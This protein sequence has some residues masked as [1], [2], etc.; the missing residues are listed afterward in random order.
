MGTN[1]EKYGK[2]E[3]IRGFRR[4]GRIDF[5]PD[6][7]GPARL[8]SAV[9]WNDPFPQALDD[10]EELSWR[11]QQMVIARMRRREQLVSIKLLPLACVL[12]A[13]FVGGA[14]TWFARSEWPAA[15]FIIAA[16]ITSGL[17]FL[18]LVLMQFFGMWE[19]RLTAWVEAFKDSHGLSTKAEEEVWKK[20]KDVSVHKEEPLTGPERPPADSDL[21][22][23]APMEPNVNPSETRRARREMAEKGLSMDSSNGKP[24]IDDRTSVESGSHAS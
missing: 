1:E 4:V 19:P 20:K 16:G 13:V 14:V 6:A 23:P 22:M 9:L 7:K 12:L 2:N 3:G 8:E 21:P 15:E 10:F 11:D 5:A 18:I 17:L 24:N